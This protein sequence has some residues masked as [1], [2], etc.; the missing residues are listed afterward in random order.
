MDSHS[1]SSLFRNERELFTSN[2]RLK[3]SNEGQKLVQLGSHIYPG[4][5]PEAKRTGSNLGLVSTPVFKGIV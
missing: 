5:I 1:N 4:S 3:S 2:S